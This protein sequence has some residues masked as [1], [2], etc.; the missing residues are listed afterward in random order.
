MSTLREFVAVY[1][2]YRVAHP[3]SYSLKRAWT[4]AVLKWSF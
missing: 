1:R 3:V 2:L 4:I